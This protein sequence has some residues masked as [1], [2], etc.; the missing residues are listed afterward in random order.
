MGIGP[1]RKV[2]DEQS[3]G[4]IG[5]LRN[6]AKRLGEQVIRRAVAQAMREMGRQFV[7]GETIESAMERAKGMEAKGIV[8]LTTCSG[9]Q[10]KPGL[11][12]SIIIFPIR[13]PL[14]TH[15]K[16]APLKIYVKTPVFRS[17]FPPFILGMIGQ[18]KRVMSE[19]VVVRPSPF[20]KICPYGVKH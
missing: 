16:L 14:P 8:I 12:P 9:K 4:V 7:L 18:K 10:P 11:M 3:P 1:D 20:G 15:F 13:K 19:L 6:F 2:L 5:H 17:N